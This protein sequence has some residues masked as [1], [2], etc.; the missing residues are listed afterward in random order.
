MNKNE[1][2][3]VVKHAGGS[4]LTRICRSADLTAT[5]KDL[6]QTLNIQLKSFAGIKT[7]HL[8]SLV[9]LWQ[10]QGK[11]ERTIHNK[12]SHMRAALKAMDRERFAKAAQNTNASL[13]ASSASRAGTHKVI[14]EN[15][16][17]ER[18]NL[19][20]ESFRA[21]AQLQL[22]IGLR[23]QE[24]VQSNQS[25]KSWEK[26]IQSGRP[27]MVL[28]GTKGGRQRFVS[29]LDERSKQSALEAV[30]EAIRVAD[31]QDG[32]LIKSRSLQGANRAFQRAMNKVGFKGREAS[33]AMRYMFAQEQFSKYLESLGSKSEALAALSMDLGHGDTRG[34]YCQQVYLRG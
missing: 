1:I 4:T 23:A 2:K 13:G 6:R 17:N 14:N 12:L 33:H 28:H 30:R 29:L 11:S 7:Q 20:P 31:T 16:L 8:K 26:Q 25:L 5:V 22:A 32:Q 18:L 10:E 9:S 15:T 27:V 24:A 21:A 3:A 19:L 34:Q